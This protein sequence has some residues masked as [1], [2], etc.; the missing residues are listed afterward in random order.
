MH[1]SLRDDRDA[2]SASSSNFNFEYVMEFIQF[3]TAH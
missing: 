1:F 2:I 3:S